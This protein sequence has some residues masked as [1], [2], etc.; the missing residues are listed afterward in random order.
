VMNEP[1]LGD[2]RA[3]ATVVDI[4]NALRL[5]LAAA[6]CFAVV[7]LSVLAVRHLL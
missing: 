3:R 4:G 1:W 2:G 5:Y 7:L 6:A